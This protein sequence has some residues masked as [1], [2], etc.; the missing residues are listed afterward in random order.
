M[1]IF[2]THTHLN[3][4]AFV[5]NVDYYIEKAIEMSVKEM[6]VVGVNTKSNQQSLDLSS[7]YQ[8][9][10]SI[11]GYHPTDI[12][13]YNKETE[14]LLIEQLQ[15]P[16]VVAL[17]EIGLDYYWMEDEP[18]YQQEI[19]RRQLAIA[20]SLKLPVSFHTRSKDINDDQAYQDL[21]QVL[22]EENITEIGGIIHSFNG[23][24][25]WAKRF[26][27]LGLYI[28]FSGVLTF[29]NA[30]ATQE[31]IK[32]INPKQILV[33]TDAPYLAPVP[34]RGKQNEPAYTYYVIQKVAE[35]LE[36][37]EE[38]AASLTTQ[39]AHRLFSLESLNGE[40]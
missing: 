24:T 18:S 28:S 30:K 11:I 14:Q 19:L 37:T 29:K 34:K 13:E 39:N 9:L 32:V 4:E 5:N 26:E 38:Q 21:Y 27:D 33:E 36:I 31:A 15:Q 7:K 6:A 35:L 17:G 16:K 10:Y 23:D 22:K 1:H 20:R 3:D 12:K 2:D 8:G 25:E 40:D